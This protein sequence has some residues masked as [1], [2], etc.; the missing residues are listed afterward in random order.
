MTAAAET[1]EA[2]A[3]RIGRHAWVEQNL[4]ET[5]GGWVTSAPEPAAKAVLA[6][7]SLHHAWRAEQWYGLLPAVP[8]L[9]VEDLVT[10][11]PGRAPTPRRR[12]RGPP[13]MAGRP[14]PA[15]A[16]GRLRRPPRGDDAADR[17]THD[18]D[19]RAGHRRRARRP[20]RGRGPAA[21][22]H[23]GDIGQGGDGCGWPPTLRRS[24]A[25]ARCWSALT[26]PSR[27][28]IIRATTST[29]RSATM[30]S[31]TTSRWSRR[32]HGEQV[33]APPHG[34]WRR[35]RPPPRRR[36][37]SSRRRR[38]RPAPATAVRPT[39]RSST[40]RWWAMVNSHDR[41]PRSSPSNRGRFRWTW[42]NTSL[43]RPSG[44]LAR[45]QR[46]YEAT[47]PASRRYRRSNDT[48]HPAL[49]AATRGASTHT[50]A[51]GSLSARGGRVGAATTVA[52]PRSSPR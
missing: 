13:R 31:S 10:P 15:C 28:F 45:C 26:A 50:S 38:R 49:A 11:P 51:G 27:L 44:S 42:A 29:G 18:P 5:V 40:M 21:A 48:A 3:R 17:R 8:H 25:S 46:R 7:Q 33:V 41:K 39:R 4:F 12:D 43:V 19:P 16:A 30:R 37:P 9:A 20:G 34:T 24:V 1:L 35:G 32:Q 2:S 23:P 6:A 22:R 14:G 47:C 52:A 36:R